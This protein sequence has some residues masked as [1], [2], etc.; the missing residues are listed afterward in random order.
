MGDE[1]VIRARA[2]AVALVTAVVQHS[3]TVSNAKEIAGAV[4][5]LTH[6]LLAAERPPAATVATA[7]H[8]VTDAQ[9]EAWAAEAWDTYA[10]QHGPSER[11]MGIAVRHVLTLAGVIESAE[12]GAST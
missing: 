4:E 12:K 2:H 1:R 9:I 5:D 6:E 11:A 10:R 3:W 7:R 8:T